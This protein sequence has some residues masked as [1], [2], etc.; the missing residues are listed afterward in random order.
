ENQTHILLLNP[1]K[2]FGLFSLV[3]RTKLC[4]IPKGI[5]NT[6]RSPPGITNTN[7]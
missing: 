1:K 2:A 3:R 4:V 5:T 7:L 6:A